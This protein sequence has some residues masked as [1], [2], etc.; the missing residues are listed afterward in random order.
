MKKNKKDPERL[1]LVKK[2]IAWWI[3]K[4][5]LKNP[6]QRIVVLF[7]MTDAGFSNIDIELVK[8]QVFCFTTYYPAMLGES[9]TKLPVFF[10]IT[11][12][13]SH[14]RRH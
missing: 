14:E 5:Y 11:T 8:F 10:T 1:T 13:L 2:F 12:F 3:D 6:D 4:H 9:V 7:D